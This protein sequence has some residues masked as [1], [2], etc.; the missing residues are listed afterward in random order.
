MLYL[1]S[2][3]AAVCNFLW[4]SNFDIS[5]VISSLNHIDAVIN[6]GKVNSWRF[7]GFYGCPETHKHHE[8][9]NVLKNLNLSSYLPWLCARD[10]KEIVKSHEKMGG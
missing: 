8:S 5:V 9:W 7:T 1:R 6:A 2:I 3:R 4:K 10:F